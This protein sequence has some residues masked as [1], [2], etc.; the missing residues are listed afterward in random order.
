MTT[1][2]GTPAQINTDSSYKAL[3]PNMNIKLN[4]TDDVVG[5]VAASRSLTRP[6]LNYMSPATNVVTTR[7]G[8]LATAAGNP[9]LKPFLSDN[10]DLSL[11]WYYGDSSYMSIG[12]F[13]KDVSNFITTTTKKQTFTTSNG[14]L[15]TDPSSGTNPNA[16]DA[17]DA[18]AS[19]TQTLP[20][21]GETAVV[22]GLEL[23]LQHTFGETGFG[24][25]VNGTLVDSDAPLKAGDITQKFA[26]T[27]I[28]NSAN[29]VGFYE[30]GPYQ[31][32]LAYN[33]RDKFLQSMTQTN[34]DGVVNVAA[35]GQWDLS[36]SYAITDNI[37]VVLEATNLTEEVVTKYGRY[38]N[39]F[40]LAEDAGRRIAVGLTAKF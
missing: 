19:F 33:W 14:S 11:E 40:L 12:Y 1:V 9:E 17:G 26:V 15:L 34:G 3:L 7:P 25:I 5:R 6:Q 23:A 31:V 20:S 35:Y 28:S 2:Y 38:T 8:T 39:Q 29:L 30:Q 13:W 21:N 22:D 27:G 18:V 37:S 10:L 4:I 16:P 32:R 36:G 24:V